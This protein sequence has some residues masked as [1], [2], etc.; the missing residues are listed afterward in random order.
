LKGLLRAA[1]LGT[2]LIQASCAPEP[3]SRP[4]VLL[5]SI[6]TLRADHLGCYGYELPT[7]PAIDALAARGVRFTRNFSQSN[8][9]LP[10]HASLLTSLFPAEFQITRDDGA[11]TR[12]QDTKL[13]LPEAVETLAEVASSAGYHTGAFTDGGLVA[14]RYGIGQGFDTF[15]AARTSEAQGFDTTLPAF[16]RWLDDWKAADD[17]TPFFAFVHSYDVHDPYRAPPPFDRAFTERRSEDFLVTRGFMPT[18]LD[19]RQRMPEPSASEL[20]E[21][22]RFYD[23]GIAYA[24]RGVG[25]LGLILEESEVWDNTLVVLVSDHGEEFKEHGSW[26]HGPQLFDELLHVPLIVRFPHDQYAGRVVEQVV[27]SVDIAPTVA[28]VIDAPMG[29]AWV[30]TSLME[31]L[32]GEGEDRP[33]IS[34][35]SNAQLGTLSMRVGD[36][37]VIDVP[38]LDRELLFNT[39][40]DPGEHVDLARSRPAVLAEMR[41]EL[42]RWRASL[43]AGSKSLRAVPMGEEAQ[44]LQELEAELLGKM[45]Y[46][47]D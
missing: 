32:D 25:L 26:G 15:Q 14:P 27:R 8:Q 31:L 24:D 42:R 37:K 1:L 10:S 39:A 18:A 45:G 7:S 23:N 9:T 2:A 35:L 20:D 22:R 17:G 5:I 44:N 4:N 40:K 16:K 28:E 21:I 46:V 38:S 19:L 13:R 12:Q 6:D 29:A 43:A 30:G 11:N 33:V 47:D 34:E 36:L 3:R 41:D